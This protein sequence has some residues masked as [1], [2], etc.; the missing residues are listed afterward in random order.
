MRAGFYV[1]MASYFKWQA[2]VR[3]EKEL[4]CSVAAKPGCGWGAGERP[5]GQL[6]PPLDVLLGAGQGKLY[7]DVCVFCVYIWIMCLFTSIYTRIFVW[8]ER[9]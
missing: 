2:W 3:E 4:L 5:P 7:V 6:V 9:L 1:L 8:R